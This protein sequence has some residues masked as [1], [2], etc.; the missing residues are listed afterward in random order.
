[1]NMTERIYAEL[2]S[3]GYK[4]QTVSIEHLA[5]LQQEIGT[6]YEQGVIDKKLDEQYLQKNYD[7]ALREQFPTAQTLII[8]AGPCRNTRLVFT[9][10][11][12]QIPVILPA[13]YAQEDRN[14]QQFEQKAETA[15][16][17]V[18]RQD[19]YQIRQARVPEKL[20]AVHSGLGRYGKNNVC[21]V[22]G[23]GSFHTLAAFWS[24]LPCEDDS[25]QELAMS[26]E[27]RKCSACLK[28]CPTGAIV[29][30][31]F[32][33]HAERCLTFFNELPG[34]FPDWIEPSWHHCLVGCLR[35]QQVCPQ[36]SHAV[37]DVN[38]TVEFTEDETGLLL[39]ENQYENFPANLNMK[40]R[41]LGLG[42]YRRVLARNLNA[43]LR[44]HNESGGRS[45][46]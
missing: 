22:P 24:D 11:G 12:Q 36:N 15:I 32:L 35:C 3:E 5:T 30:D 46:L 2:Q 7:F 29:K 27:C 25:W 28:Q 21:Y 16:S 41:K 37:N 43:A 44:N 4:A 34:A 45:S 38:D 40:L 19:S 17:Q 33:I 13:G 8:V 39:K 10:H 18:F 1:M 31:R 26:E 14:R 9:R 6:L 23:M 20:L 42:H